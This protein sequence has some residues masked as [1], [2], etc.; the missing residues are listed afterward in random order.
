[1][2]LRATAMAEELRRRPTASTWPLARRLY[3]DAAAIYRRHGDRR[4][5]ADVEARL[6]WLL[7]QRLQQ[8]AAAAAAY[9][10]ARAVFSRLGD[11]RRVARLL[12]LRGQL[13]MEGR[14]FAEALSLAHQAAGVCAQLGDARCEAVA[15]N[16]IGYLQ[17][18]LGQ[19]H[20]SL[21]AYT[22]SLERWATLSAA[23]G[24][25]TTLHNRGVLYYSLGNYQAALDDLEEARQ[26]RSG[27]P[28]ELASTLTWIGV[29]YTSTGEWDEALTLLLEALRLRVA[30]GD[31]RGEAATETALGF[32]LQRLGKARES[33]ARHRRAFEI[34]GT[35]ADEGDRARA[36]YNYGQALRELGRR[37]EAAPLL[38]R[39]LA[40]GRTQGDDELVQA[41][42][43]ELAQLAA[44]NGRL[45][46]A[47]GLIRQA[48]DHVES[49]RLAAPSLGLRS[50]FLASRQD[51]YA[52]AVELLMRLAA[53][54]PG[55]GYARQAF[56]VSERGRARSFLDLLRESG[57]E[58]RE[59]VPRQLLETSR[60]IKAAIRRENQILLRRQ[61]LASPGE[62]ADADRRELRRLLD[63]NDRIE[64]EIRQR[65]PALRSLIQV[66]PLRLG[67]VQRQVIDA[68]TSL[69]HYQLGRE[70]SYLFLVG[71]DE[72]RTFVLPPR[73]RIERLA[74]RA[75]LLLAGG[76]EPAQTRLVLGQLAD[77][78]I[79]P[80][81][82]H[83]G[84]R[85]LLIVGDGAIHYLPFAALPLAL[86][87]ARV[88][89]VAHHEVVTIPSASALGMLKSQR[90]HSRTVPSGVAVIADPV[91]TP[92]DERVTRPSSPHAASDA[93][94]P[95]R[96]APRYDRLRH[97][98]TEAETITALAEGTRTLLAL[99]FDAS[100]ETVLS[101][102]LERHRII[103]FA[104]HGEM[105]S[106]HP[107][108]SRLVLS[109]V[110]RNGRAREG[111]L[112][113]HEI[114]GLR[115]PADLVVLSACRTGI[116]RNIRGEGLVG[117]PQAFLYAG[118]S[119]VVVSLWNVNDRSTASLFAAFY[120]HLLR[121]GQSPSA[122]L[123]AAQLEQWSQRPQSYE[124]A[125]FVIAGR[126]Q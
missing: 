113:G 54:Y 114:L 90:A 75:Y 118:T 94:R 84:R 55:Q 45:P 51:Y 58:V 39:A 60:R 67:Q 49:A 109:L 4:G 121:E 73:E 43:F 85:R 23:A 42:L 95:L 61:L 35:L 33:L 46:A 64:A 7:H 78:I 27:S 86:S 37:A 63:S 111:F 52:F 62:P 83:L 57:V 13:A 77:A 15:L 41:S 119:R 44:A 120:R 1:M 48:L 115:I 16:E 103:H 106:Q 124:W 123:R 29:T 74:T 31:R 40:A 99:D 122:A 72:L 91:F 92:D 104:T 25:G 105:D 82:A 126:W 93:S 50:T 30:A 68:E 56:D 19:P 32:V 76:T 34:Y 70:R 10:S 65:S 96:F 12:T 9:D 28:A 6:G 117:L 102:L 2:A 36:F 71:R 8:P 66:E 100:R 88:P 47:V 108:L 98:R 3:G 116:G 26:L 5:E 110:D 17:Q 20:A 101:A 80:A 38:E 22:H 18:L 81:A 53:Q 69:L 24:H 11:H 21:T 125:A 107:E 59:G 112:Y 97:S 14:R 89:L 79:A 87:G